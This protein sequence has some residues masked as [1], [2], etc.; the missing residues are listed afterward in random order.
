[1]VGDKVGQRGSLSQFLPEFGDCW[2][3]QTTYISRNSVET[4]DRGREVH[5]QT[6][7]GEAQFGDR[8]WP[9]CLARPFEPNNPSMNALSR[10]EED[11]LLKTTKARALKECD[12]VVKGLPLIRFTEYLL[13]TEYLRRLC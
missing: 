13:E 9:K 5:V 12:K 4:S 2:C 1:M 11:A 8:Q 3:C 6:F 10:R 7:K